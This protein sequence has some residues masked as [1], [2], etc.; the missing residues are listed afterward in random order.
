MVAGTVVG[1]AVCHAAENRQLVHHGGYAGKHIGDMQTGH[2]GFDGPELA[3]NFRRSVRFEI[4]HVL[5]GHPADGE[6]E[7]AVHILLGR[8]SRTGV[9]QA[10]HLS[11]T[12]PGQRTGLQE[13][14]A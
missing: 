12:Q 6:Q 3:A 5:M 14:S 7:D 4:P 2:V 11:E 13:F 10:E 8:F 9:L 1:L